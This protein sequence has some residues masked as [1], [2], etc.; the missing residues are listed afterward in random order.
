M[1]PIDASAYECVT[2]VARL[3]H[4]IAKAREAGVCG[5]DTETDSLEAVTAR[6]VGFSLAIAPGEACYMPLGAWRH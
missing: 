4:W 1:P 5:F 3:D 2:D 6:L